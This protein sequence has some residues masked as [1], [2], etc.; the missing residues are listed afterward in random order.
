MKIALVGYGKMGKEIEQI[1]ISRGHEIAL[2]VNSSNADTFSNEELK[3]ADVA[4]EFSV[5]QSAIN[6]INRC[7]DTN[8]PVVVGTTA[9][10]DK[11]EDVI[12]RCIDNNGALLYSSNFSIGVN[13]FFQLNEKL[14]EL[15]KPYNEYEVTM[16]EIHHVHKLD[17]PSGTA[18]TL[19]NEIIEQLPR[20][21]KWVVNTG[22]KANEIEIRAIR[23]NSV[24][25]THSI[26][27]NSEIDSISIEHIAHNRKGFALG[28]VIAAEYLKDKKGIY[29]M[30]DVL[31]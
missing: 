15:M 11:K 6:N 10:L 30:R 20:K 27:Y 22:A 17:A 7:I 23:T 28:A 2:K 8:V 31:K 25:G 1:A 21:N 16:E 9:W 12:I 14:A 3:M 4:I 13:L 19:A 18:I 26:T 5:P 29:T 24:P